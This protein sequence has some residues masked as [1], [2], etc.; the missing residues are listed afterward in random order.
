M[1]QKQQKSSIQHQKQVISIAKKIATSPQAQA[2][3]IQPQIMP[4]F[5]ATQNLTPPRIVSHSHLQHQLLEQARAK[6][7]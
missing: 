5:I 3:V 6:Y 7:S 1:P 4:T 2:K